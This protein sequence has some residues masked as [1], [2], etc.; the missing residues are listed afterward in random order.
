M[1]PQ[2]DRIER[3]IRLKATFARVW[4]ALTDTKEFG[5]WFGVDLKGAFAPGAVMRGTLRPTTADAQVA[6]AQQAYAGRPWEVTVD[7][8]ETE[9]RFSFYWHPHA[10]ETG[11]DYSVEPPTLVTFELIPLEEGT[12]LKVRE[13]G[14]DRLP[15]ARRAKAFRRNEEG[16]DTMLKVLAR[17]LDQTK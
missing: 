11:V 14:F 6:A 7:R 16:W 12:L 5:S 2:T 1:E 15:I 8:M 4:R 3:E 13:S 17:H 10:I 9:E